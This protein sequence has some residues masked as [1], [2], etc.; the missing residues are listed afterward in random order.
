M[1][2]S[3]TPA[4]QSCSP[5]RAPPR[6]PHSC[7]LATWCTCTSLWPSSKCSRWAAGSA[8]LPL[9][10]SITPGARAPRRPCSRAAA[11][12]H[13]PTHA[14]SLP[15]PRLPAPPGLHPHHHHALPVCGPAGDAHPPPGHVCVFHRGRHRAGQRGRGALRACSAA[16]G[17]RRRRLHR[18]RFCIWALLGARGLRAPPA[19]PALRCATPALEQPPTAL[20]AA[21]LCD[22]ACLPDMTPLHT[23]HC[24]SPHCMPRAWRPPS[25]QA[26]LDWAGILIMFLSEL[27]ESI[28]LVMTQLLLTGLRFH[29]SEPL[30]QPAPAPRGGLQGCRAAARERRCQGCV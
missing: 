29:P 2:P 13:P 17:R 27:F 14:P 24:T 30:P 7:T 18:R 5:D 1:L 26:N 19:Q 22:L 10:S 16:P 21:T 4:S 15:P 3:A 8:D 11:P 28:R 23:L 9:L 6:C 25:L 20:L 12:A